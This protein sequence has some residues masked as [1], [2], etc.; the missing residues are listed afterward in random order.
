M[1]SKQTIVREPNPRKEANIFS[2]LTFGYTLPTFRK[3]FNKDLQEEDIPE[4]WSAHASRELG[5]RLEEAWNKEL[6][7]RKNPSLWR[8]LARV[9]GLDFMVI[10]LAILFLEVVFR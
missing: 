3:G 7:T 5:N 2:I 4:N 8:A 10:G 6:K 9:F 1:D